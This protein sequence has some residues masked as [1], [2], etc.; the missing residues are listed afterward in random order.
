MSNL[1][2]IASATAALRA[3][4]AEVL[5]LAVAGATASVARVGDTAGTGGLPAVGANVFLT[6]TRPN[7]ALRNADLPQRGRDGGLHQPPV[8]AIDLDCLLSFYGPDMTTVYR[9]LGAALVSLHARPLLTPAMIL[10]AEAGLP[11]SLL[12][13]Q[14]EPLRITLLDMPLEEMSRLWSVL[15][16]TRYVPSLALRLGPV[17][18]EAPLEVAPGLPVRAFGL[19]VVAGAAPELSGLVAAGDP[20]G[21]VEPGGRVALLGRFDAG[22]PL[23]VLVDGAELALVAPARA[24]RLEVV[25]PAGLAPGPHQAVVRADVT[26][27]GAL[28]VA[29]ARRPG[30][31]SNLLP[32]M[33]QPAIALAAGQPDIAVAAGPGGPVLSVRLTQ[34]L[35][36]GG[37]ALLHLIA[38]ADGEVRLVRAAP[39]AAAGAVLDFPVAGVPAGE[40]VVRVAVG[41][42]L[43]H[44]VREEAPGHPRR[45]RFVAPAVVVP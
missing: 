6:G 13:R 22:R 2:A 26:L 17:L 38:P 35:P 32:F 44:A 28:G 33:V 21:P 10:A 14:P 29:P 23:A 9:L 11:A 25:L 31:A 18:L 5:P 43:S 4:M 42:A 34:P 15:L 3:R 27:G 12:D 37:E 16:Q 36:E 19:A 41:G 39:L 40:Y 8:A 30:I 7:A 45:G 20:A 24:E 1:H